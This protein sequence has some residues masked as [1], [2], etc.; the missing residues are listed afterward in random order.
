MLTSYVWAKEENRKIF[1][2]ENYK[3]EAQI[4]VFYMYMNAVILI[5]P[6]GFTPCTACLKSPFET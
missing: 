1:D 4:T 6:F 5:Q 2:F 3:I